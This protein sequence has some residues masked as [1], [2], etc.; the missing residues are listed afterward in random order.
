MKKKLL[1]LLLVLVMVLGMFPMSAMAAET[2][3]NAGY[4]IKTGHTSANGGEMVITNINI[5]GA[6]VV[7][8]QK[9]G[10]NDYAGIVYLAA[11]TDP[12][13]ELTFT[14]DGIANPFFDSLCKI[15]VNDKQTG[16][17]TLVSGGQKT[18]SEITW[19]HKM[20]PA[21]ENG[22]ATIAFKSQGANNR[23]AKNYTLE[24]RIQSEEN[25]AP[26]LKN[27][28]E[29][30]INVYVGVNESYAV[31]LSDI[32]EDLEQDDLK[33]SV[34]V[35]EAT[36]TE[37]AFWWQYTP[38]TA[39]IHT[40]VFKC[41]DSNGNEAEDSYT[42]KLHAVTMKGF[43]T[44]IQSGDYLNPA[45][46]HI[47]IGSAET[48]ITGDENCEAYVLLDS[49]FRRG[50][51]VYFKLKL[52][53][54]NGFA[55]MSMDFSGERN[56]DGK[57]DTQ[58]YIWS[59]TFVPTWNNKGEAEVKIAVDKN[60]GTTWPALSGNQY[61][62]RLKLTPTENTAPAL[63]G[64]ASG[65]DSVMQYSDYKVN[66]KNLFADTDDSW[67]LYSVA[68]GDGEFAACGESYVFNSKTTGE[69][70]VKFKAEDISGSESPVYTLTLNVTDYVAPSG[71][72]YIGDT[73]EDGAVLDVTFLDNSGN[74]IEGVT[75]TVGEKVEEDET[76][77]GYTYK[78]WH[79]I[80]DVALPGNEGQVGTGDTIKAY[81]HL[82]QTGDW[83]W[84]TAGG[85]AVGNTDHRWDT[86]KTDTIKTTLKGGLATG[87]GNMYETEPTRENNEHYIYEIRYHIERENNQA[88]TLKDGVTS[89][90]EVVQEQYTSYILNAKNLLADPE[91]D[92]ITYYI[93]INNGDFEEFKADNRGD[94][95]RTFDLSEAGET[96]I[97]LKAKDA[98]GA[99]SDVV[100]IS[101]TATP[102]LRYVIETGEGASD[103][104][105][106]LNKIFLYGIEGE[107]HVVTKD[108][109]N[110]EIVVRM[111]AGTADT[112]EIEVRW[113]G[114]ADNITTNVDNPIELVDGKAEVT[115]ESHGHSSDSGHKFYKIIIT[116][117]P[118][119]KPV[120]SKNVEATTA[121]NVLIGKAYELDLSTIF[122]DAD[123]D[124]LTY[125]VSVNGADAVAADADYSY[126]PAELGTYTL[127]FRAADMWGTSDE[128]YTVK[129]TAK[130]SDELN[131]VTFKVPK[132]V[133]P[134][135]YGSTGYDENYQDILSAQLNA[136]A[137]AT[138]DGW[139]TYTV[140]VPDNFR[141]VSFRGTVGET[142]WGGMSV[143]VKDYEDKVITEPFVLRQLEG[144]INTKLNSDGEQVAP[145]TAQ[146][147][148]QVKYGEGAYAITGG[149]F[150]DQYGN[151]GYRFLLL[152]ADNS[153][154][155]TYY[156]QPLGD[157]AS[158]YAESQGDTKTV[159]SEVAT[160]ATA[161]MK[162][163]NKSAFKITAP[164]AATVQFFRQL[165]N[166]NVIELQA[167]ETVNNNDGTK[168]VTFNSN[169]GMFRV[170][171]DGKITKAGYCDGDSITVSWDDDDRGP[172]YR[173]EYDTS[174]NF[175]A[176]G[177]DSTYVNV[178]YRNNLRLD[179]NETFQLRAY[180]LWQIINTDT[181]NIMIE[182]DFHYN[183]ISGDDVISITP[184]A[185]CSGNAKN[186]WLD[187]KG[188][189]AG[190]AVVEVTYDALDLIS[191]GS[192]DQGSILAAN[193]FTFNA[194]DPDR[195]ALIV[196]Q[197]GAEQSDVDFGIRNNAGNVWDAE[198]DTLCFTENSM[199]LKFKPTAAT[200]TIS[201][202]EVSGDKG[203]TWTILNAVEGEYTATIVPGNNIVRI[204]KEDGTVSHQIV[205]GYKLTIVVSEVE[206]KSDMDGT[207]E[208]GE[209][210]NLWLKGYHNPVG[211]MSGIYN[212]QSTT[213]HFTV[214]RQKISSV[215]GAYAFYGDARINVMIPGN[216]VSGD[217]IVLE[218]GYA[219]TS[220]FGVGSG[221]HRGITGEVP[222]NLDADT[223]GGG[224]N[225]YDD[226]VITVGASTV[227]EIVEVTG[228]SLNSDVASVEDGK[229][230]TLTATVSPANATDKT[231]TWT[232]SN[233]A[234]ATV[235]SSGR[236]T[237]VS[238][239]TA[240]I[241]AK[242]GEYSDTC[243][244]TVT[245]ATGGNTPGGNP[246]L[247][248]GLSQDEILGYVTVSFVDNGV[249]KSEELNDPNATYPI[250]PEF[251]NPLGTIIPATRVPFKAYDTIASVTLRL[252]DENEFYANYQGDE[253][254][255]F[256]LAAIGD[257]IHRGT[258]YESFG[259]FDAGA[260]S[261][262]MITWDDWFINKGASE[263]MVE[264]GDVVAWQY[265]CQ[266]GADIGDKD[267][268]NNT[269]KPGG[270]PD[271]DADGEITVPISG[272]ENTI[273]VGA[274]VEG[275]KA[276]IDEVDLTDLNKV[277]GDQVDTG[278]VTID[279]SG[280]ESD[281]AIT[282]V[283][284]PADTVKKIAEA[285]NDPKN[286]AHSLEIVLSDGVSI[287]F[288]AAALKEKASQA[289]GADI[290]IS[291][292]S[293]ENVTLTNAQK[294]ALGDRPAYDI[295]VTSGGEHISDMGGKITVHAPYVL[296]GNEKARGIVVWYV[297][298]NGNK[299][300]CVTSY[301]PIKKRVNWKTD[302]L[303][304]YM[305]DYDETLANNP[306][307]DVTMDNYYF[308]AV[309][310]AV[311]EGITVGTS[312]TT[313][314]PDAS[315]T[316]AQMVTFLWRAAGSPKA[317]VSTC[318]FTDVDKDAYYY[319]ALL[320]AV[321]N[322]ITSGTSATTF[323]PN[324][325]CTR[326]QMAT[327]LYRDAKSP[328]VTG[329]HAFTDV[330]ADAYYNDDV[331][332]AAAEGI[333]VGTSDTTFSPDADCT[334]GQMVT[335]LYRYLAE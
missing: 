311:D 202:V 104:T 91:G 121:E 225:I 304:L 218:D 253:Y 183:V 158:T 50:D 191:N 41:K 233:T 166:Y 168:T 229:S 329:T 2:E 331:I 335:F 162:L 127:V 5:S 282:T 120:L 141:R 83:P 137:G 57:L 39:G 270:T 261:G 255:S 97:A 295:N 24:F 222:P 271:D 175:G 242:I 18:L 149:H 74:I 47:D 330:K 114:Y 148:F 284:L 226:I 134:V 239:G 69:K 309:L 190:T 208:K 180:R 290:T 245:E 219:T 152:A 227:G 93:S 221:A 276:T 155:Y 266:L 244:V 12:E 326:G 288:D 113:E 265:T 178:N 26:V 76:N 280:L 273:H 238:E 171:M 313:F 254:S 274:T 40:L 119:N 165:G 248:F 173:A 170:S 17:I 209:T 54:F 296:K 300:R 294:K 210:V 159:T 243:T 308:D 172:G 53:N 84:F 146:A 79:R 147:V 96:Q 334:R 58:N 102:V 85:N 164:S 269:G 131:T 211:K 188:L 302:H 205:R 143:A 86:Q 55:Q 13:A 301:D 179:E 310:W 25:T 291:I 117:E 256:Y 252:L 197:V 68:I 92:A 49:S 21:W 275:A 267:W 305:I 65:S 223:V 98:L 285:V 232:S 195:T 73:T 75:A 130:N 82:V 185:G 60:N 94:V 318:A 122:T 324:A 203:K 263:F 317:S 169:N 236:V 22:K 154:V 144:I 19:T 34:S 20:V 237:G 251:R 228:I 67:L 303:S 240:T 4:D 297:D 196:V 198:H 88:P 46:S 333:T 292:E 7:K 112:A 298:D 320:W 181:A 33:Y 312:D 322:G 212:T 145:T 174:T 201:K 163:A 42:V 153:L 235:S 100:N 14:L 224:F 71:S 110:R 8:E 105:S 184:S 64:E 124:E 135:F 161:V 234:V 177:N 123:D 128:T 70:T 220:G 283:E 116:N 247:K 30:E 315:C 258:Y 66:V 150:N 51:A 45:I 230:I 38:T 293:H 204:T 216:A 332:W 217:T 125:T 59:G 323:S 35:N 111:K 192:R 81:F 250:L 133:T 249:R 101:L 278:T 156:A 52:H 136:V 306:F 319:E 279:F 87:F 268:Q 262:W 78:V 142:A 206:G 28:D 286:D 103:S 132:D 194:V 31:T 272:D 325:S 213:L 314:S 32:W 231:V 15:F 56:N 214:N 9:T 157:L 287:E 246:E 118:N 63:S 193:H 1:S 16:T 277:V 72:F 316:R 89:P 61:K 44:K 176:R 327:F 77:W 107:K 189:K 6:E 138:A 11:N 259:E 299:E 260:D 99:E 182:P 160:K 264:D 139:T 48:I 126:I 151:L 37:A 307:T 3:A 108:G 199:E 115:I 80:I 109:Q 328:A 215:C 187:I 186:N 281:E 207:I 241:T 36:A 289:N 321:E 23:V 90:V 106:G 10:D 129:L 257:F 27:K 95:T 43:D 200:G 140:S 62:I 167:Y 29:K